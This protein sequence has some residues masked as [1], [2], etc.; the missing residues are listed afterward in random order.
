MEIYTE[1]EREYHSDI[2]EDAIDFLEKKKPNFEIP[3][4]DHIDMIIGYNAHMDMLKGTEDIYDTEEYVKLFEHSEILVR[5]LAEVYHKTGELNLQTYY[6]FCKTI[7]K[8][9]EIIATDTGAT[10]IGIEQ[11]F[12]KM[13]V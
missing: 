7:Q 1:D 6:I 8:M 3:I 2:I 12:Q 13:K 4:K 5:Y 10:D 9:M 11:M